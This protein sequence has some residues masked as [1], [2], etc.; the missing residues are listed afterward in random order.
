M[1]ARP[2]LSDVGLAV[3]VVAGLILTFAFA[4]FGQFWIAPLS[5]AA[6]IVAWRGADP[7]RAFR[8]GFAFGVASFL[9]GVHWV[10]ISIHDYGPAPVAFAAAVTV[11][12]VTLLAVFP[13]IAGWVAARWFT[14]DGPAAWLGVF[15]AVWTLVE[16]LRG[17]VF[18]GF[19]WLSAG[20]TQTDSWIM[21]FAPLGGLHFMGWAVLLTAGAIVML[22]R[23]SA[24]QR[25]V[26]AVFAAS[27]WVVAWLI[28]STS[29]T[30]PL[31]EELSVA[32]VQGAVPQELKWEVEQFAPTLELYRGLTYE[33]AGSE[34]IVWP[35][36]AIPTLYGNVGE[37]L[38]EIQEWADRNGSEILLGI[39]R[40]DPERSAV[41]NTIV[42]L[43]ESH[44]FYIKRHL[45]PYGEY[46]PVPGFVRN[47]LRLMS[48][49][50]NDAR[51]GPADQ[52]PLQ[53]AGQRIA[54]SICY[55]DVF[56]AEQLHYLPDA[57]LLVN[58]SNDAWFGDSIAPHQ[59]LQIARVRA[60]EAGRFML[61]AT[62]TGVSGIIDTTG[63]VVATSPQFEPHVLRGVVRGYR[64]STPYA[65]WGNYAVIAACLLVLLAQLSTTKFTMRPG[66]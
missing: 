60:A 64:G 39:L 35:E 7:R 27:I 62:N 31:E 10:Y 55:E 20:Y 48:L 36:A 23:G 33:S 56:G 42:A 15:P 58:V 41:Q 38:T 21:G 26:A 19:G 17:W 59:H 66:T 28:G 61:R 49:P 45:V 22:V 40:A 43:G 44:S 37:Y 52:P 16:W 25:A 29:W 18:T 47:W 51:P 65:R 63:A 30:E 5:Y 6:L 32:L 9:G 4:P 8:L 46:F 1:T 11:L 24:R 13:A 34:L 3:A 14:T 54:A 53:I 2:V 57:T 50:Y 12:L